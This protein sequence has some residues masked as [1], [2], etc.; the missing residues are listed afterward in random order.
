MKKICVQ[1]IFIAFFQ[2]VITNYV[3]AAENTSTPDIFSMFVRMV[4]V[5]SLVL[6]LILV[7]SYL[8]R[9]ISFQGKI[10]PNTKKNMHVIETLYMGPKKSVTLLQVG[11]EFIL[12][13]TTQTQINFLSK[14]N[15]SDKN[16]TDTGSN[17]DKEFSKLLSSENSKYECENSSTFPFIR[18]KKT[19]SVLNI[20]KRVFSQNVMLQKTGKSAKR[21][22]Q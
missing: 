17:Q 21:G 11:C 16:F 4:S 15:L 9:R 20:I 2:F 18:G 12:I 5:L 3:W 14:I 6:G 10:F 7:A 22:T 13:G 1:V 19:D 8:F